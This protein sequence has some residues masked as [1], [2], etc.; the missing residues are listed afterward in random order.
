MAKNIPKIADSV[1]EKLKNEG[2]VIQRYDS[3]TT[4]SVYLKLDYGVANSIRISD[5]KGKKHLQ[6]RYNLLSTVNGIHR[7]KSPQGLGRYYYSFDAVEVMFQDIIEARVLKMLQCGTEQYA[8]YMETNKL[9]G[10]Y[11][12]GFWAKCVEV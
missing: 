8:K 11:Q 1:I 2:F 5:H 6:Y 4:N 3:Y 7:H 12:L 9:N 10:Q